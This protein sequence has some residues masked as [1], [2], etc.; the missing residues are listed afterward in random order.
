MA[1]L[2]YDLGRDKSSGQ[3]QLSL[4]KIVYT[5]FEPSLNRITKP[6][7]GDMTLFLSAL[8]SKLDEKLDSDG[9]APDAP[10]LNDLL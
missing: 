5:S 9:N 7:R 2:I 10:T 4:E 1:W 8:Q 3:F 6:E